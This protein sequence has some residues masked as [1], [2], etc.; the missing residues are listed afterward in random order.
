MR[1]IADEARFAVRSL[2]RTRTLAAAAAAVLA[3]GIG[4]NTAIFSVVNALLLR[5]LP[6]RD[7]ESLALVFETL[8][9]R[10]SRLTISAPA[11]WD[12]RHSGAFEQMAS[13]ARTAGS[14]DLGDRAVPVT[15][16]HATAWFLPLLGAP[17]QL[18]RTF[19]QG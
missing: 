7:P 3:L 5:P 10:R 1:S 8:A 6:F 11:V 13:V 4:A 15:V 16:A 14:L 2:L 12:L 9:G 17:M 19:N 18:G